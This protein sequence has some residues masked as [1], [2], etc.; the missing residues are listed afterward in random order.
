MGSSGPSGSPE[1]G[2][3]LGAFL[4]KPDPD[5][6][7][8]FLA[9]ILHENAEGAACRPHSQPGAPACG[10]LTMGGSTDDWLWTI[11][12]EEAKKSARPWQSTQTWDTDENA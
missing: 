6:S 8:A 9:A 10:D 7:A 12:V 3:F 2:A 5:D 1:A 4:G 11:G